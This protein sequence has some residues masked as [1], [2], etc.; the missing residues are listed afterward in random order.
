MFYE[1]AKMSESEICMLKNLKLFSKLTLKP[2]FFNHNFELRIALKIGE[3]GEKQP[4][5]L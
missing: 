2:I 1:V 4:L 3:C 5:Q